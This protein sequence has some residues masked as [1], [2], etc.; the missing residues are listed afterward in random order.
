MMPVDKRS[1]RL[2]VEAVDTLEVLAITGHD[3]FVVQQRR[4]SDDTVFSVDLSAASAKRAGNL[5]GFP[6]HGLV[7]DDR[8]ARVEYVENRLSALFGSVQLWNRFVQFE[9]R[10]RGDLLGTI[11]SFDEIKVSDC[12][13]VVV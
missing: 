4:R 5:P 9:Y 3:R 2:D 7:G 11:L 6:H 10:Y 13:P 12:V 8:V 1:V